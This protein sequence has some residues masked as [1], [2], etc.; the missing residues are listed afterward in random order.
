MKQP[1]IGEIVVYGEMELFVV[2]TKDN[3]PTCTGCFFSRQQCRY[4]KRKE[5]SCNTHG[6]VCTAFRRKDKKHV[7]FKTYDRQRERTGREVPR[8]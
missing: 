2:P 7:I 4:D 1:M 5:I 6:F 3:E 8:L